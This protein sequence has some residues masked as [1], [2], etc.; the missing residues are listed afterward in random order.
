MRY[1]VSLMFTLLLMSCIVFAG[2]N[3]S[4]SSAVEPA[5][6]PVNGSAD[7]GRFGVAAKVSLLGGGAEVAARVTHHS[8]VRAGFNVLD[9]SRGFDKDGINYGGHLSF[10]TI[11]AHYD[12]FPW[13]RSFHISPGM[14]AFVG[15]PITA[16]AFVPT[17][18]T[19]TL[20]STQYAS[21][22]GLTATGRVNFN[23]VSPTIT[24]G[25]G[26]LIHRDS[27]RFTI[28]FEFGVAFQGSPRTT[29]GLTGNVCNTLT[30]ECQSASSASV[31]QDVIAEQSKLNHDMRLF[32]MY[33]I[34][35]VGF[36]YKF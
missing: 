20:G 14:L 5:S 3:D 15:N 27:K 2:T 32:K 33:P 31:Q 24:A 9:Y 6:N 19:F 28:P 16:N 36:G 10:R 21:Q 30:G 8:N 35:S 11:E 4:S 7:Q 12:F 17:G 26:N 22:S 1:F 34:L 25:F 23:Q 13:A 29:L 18:Q